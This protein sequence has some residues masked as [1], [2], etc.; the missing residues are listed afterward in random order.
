MKKQAHI[1]FITAILF[2]GVI[3]TFA[4]YFGMTALMGEPAGGFADRMEQAVYENASLD[5]II[6]EIN[7]RFFRRV[8]NDNVI[9]GSD[10]FLFERRDE[11]SGYEYLLDYRGD[12]AFSDDELE[13][14]AKNI[15]LREGAYKNSGAQYML[16]ILPSVQTVYSENMPFLYGDISENTRRAQ[17]ERYLTENGISCVLDLTDEIR[18]KK[19]R[20]RLYDNTENSLNALGAYEVYRAI[21]E[22]LSARGEDVSPYTLSGSDFYSRLDAG[23]AIARSAGIQ[24]LVPNKTVALSASVEPY[25]ILGEYENFEMTKNAE[26]LG[27]SL[28]IEYTDEW[29]RIIM[30]P[31]F[32][33]SFEHVAYKANHM[34]SSFANAAAAPD[35]VLQIIS[36]SEL[37][38]LLDKKTAMT[39]G[40]GYKNEGHQMKT[41]MPTVLGQVHLDADT[42][43]IFGTA[44]LGAYVNVLGG[45]EAV[46]ERAED[47]RFFVEVTLP[48]GADSAVVDVFA[49][50]GFKK[51]SESVKLVLSRE[52]T[53][54]DGVAIGSDSRL[55]DK[56]YAI[57]EFSSAAEAAAAVELQRPFTIRELTGKKTEYVYAV[58]PTKLT[59]YRDSAPDVLADTADRLAALRA[60]LPSV[61]DPD[62]FVLDLTERMLAV[63]PVGLYYRTANE[64]TDRGSYEIY[65][66]IADAFGLVPI[67]EDRIEKTE[68]LLPGGKL[69]SSLGLDTTVVHEI[70]EGYNIKNSAVTYRFDGEADMSKKYRTENAD[71]SLPTAII[72]YDEYGAGA[73]PFLLE[74]FSEAIVYPQ[75]DFWT[76]A[77]DLE[78]LKPDY[79]IR[80]VGED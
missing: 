26:R 32:S 31:Y 75:G 68:L 36:E 5:R 37:D 57:N 49:K 44:E 14:I 47:G 18:S 51:Q 78:E 63:D 62:V 79:I 16:I 58:V 74:S 45:D 17:L 54:A 4:V 20:G 2:L 66:G 28:L 29:N 35:F 8:E 34:F 33:G 43:C 73:V 13:Q 46:R 40:A 56:K 9:I 76:I 80:V 38:S 10:G 61:L 48:Q 50:Y 23:K 42:V 39:Y 72:L 27:P 30:Q 69:I 41:E 12:L 1:N 3:C 52:D 65:L 22:E 70:K 19:D 11:K 25:E 15:E 60:V 59:A 6:N 71:K 77:S 64:P 7:F 55:F 67:G 24:H 53:E 21:A